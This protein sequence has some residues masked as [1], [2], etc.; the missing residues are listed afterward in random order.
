MMKNILYLLVLILFFACTAKKTVQK[1]NTEQNTEQHN[2]ITDTKTSQLVSKKTVV[3]QSR[4]NAKLVVKTTNYDTS[5]PID[6]A[7]G[8]P[9]I[10][11]ETTTTREESTNNDV[12]TEVNTTKKEDAAHED[13][14]KANAQFKEETKVVEKSKPINWMPYIYTFIFIA[15]VVSGFIFRNKIKAL[16]VFVRNLV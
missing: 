14:S 10:S 3:D 16:F 1:S 2:D 15:I 5:K 4:A 7:T 8:K 9:P 6:P 11:S 13:K 12:N